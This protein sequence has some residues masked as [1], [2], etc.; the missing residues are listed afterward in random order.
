M[1]SSAV[2]SLSECKWSPPTT[3][4]VASGIGTCVLLPYLLLA[5]DQGTLDA[6]V[7]AYE[8]FILGVLGVFIGNLAVHSKRET[9]VVQATMLPILLLALTVRL[10]AAHTPGHGLDLQINKGWAYSATQLGLARSYV[11]QLSG[12]LLPNYPPLI[13]TLFWLTGNLYK[14]SVSSTFDVLLPSWAI[15]IRFPAIFADLGTCAVLAQIVRTVG[16]TRMWAFPALVYALHPVALYDTS[17]WGQTDSIYTLWM[18]LALRAAY[19]ERWSSVGVWTACALLAK[20]QAAAMLP[21]LI[22]LLFR[23]ARSAIPCAAGAM[24][25]ASALLLP[26]AIGGVL[27]EV[28]AVYRHTVGGFYDTI[29][30]GAYNFWA[31]FHRT[32]RQSDTAL[33]FNLVSFRSVGLFLASLAVVHVL[34]RLRESLLHPRTPREHLLGILLSGALCT[35][36]LFIFATEMHER[37]QFAYIVLA[38][39]MAFGSIAGALLYGASSLLILLNLLGAMAFGMVDVALFRALPRGS[40]ASQSY[41]RIAGRPFFHDRRGGSAVGPLPRPAAQQMIAALP[42]AL[43]A[44]EAAHGVRHQGCAWGG[45]VGVDVRRERRAGIS[46]AKAHGTPIRRQQIGSETP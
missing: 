33:A 38:L 23:H 12:N 28:L 15:V 19:A 27:S 20:P 11:E 8:L 9:I 18:L 2:T 4:A 44:H 24:V 40:R 41:R 31:I 39:P 45:N 37:Y 32:A 16:M 35:S 46:P 22:V 43:G 17:V 26:F 42:S 1:G 14:F 36:A 25:A 13:V 3:A 29:S 21:V 30:I 7:L 10:I 34:W 5:H 6:V